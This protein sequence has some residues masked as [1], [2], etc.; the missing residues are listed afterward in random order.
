MPRP[1][2]RLRRSAADVRLVAE[3][4]LCLGVARLALLLP[5]RVIS[6]RLG[7]LAALEPQVQDQDHELGLR[8]GWAVEAAARRVPWRAVCLPQAIAA[9]LMLRRRRV[10]STLYLGIE[11]DTRLTP[12]AWLQVGDRIVVGARPRPCVPLSAFR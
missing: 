3:A 2:A 1:D 11:S 7:R 8:V 6:P 5:F 9:K 12:H 10:A 4:A